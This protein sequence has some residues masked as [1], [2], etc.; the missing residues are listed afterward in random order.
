MKDKNGNK[1]KLSFRYMTWVIGLLVI[2]T[3][4]FLTLV[5]YYDILENIETAEIIKITGTNLDSEEITFLV[6]GEEFVA[7]YQVPTTSGL[8]VYLKVGDKIQYLVSDPSVIY[9]RRPT[10]IIILTCIE[11]IIIILLIGTTIYEI[12][13]GM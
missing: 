7:Y 3:V 13:K 5:F 2:F 11:A 8:R 1:R 4:F 12:K 9:L 6:D 10:G